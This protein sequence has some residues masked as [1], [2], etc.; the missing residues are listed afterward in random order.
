MA[1]Q[2]VVSATLRV[3]TNYSLADYLATAYQ[4]AILQDFAFS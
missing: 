4:D 3:K 1:E 2:S